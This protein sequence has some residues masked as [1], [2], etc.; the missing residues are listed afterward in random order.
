MVDRHFSQPDMAELYDYFNFWRCTPQDDFYLDLVMDAR[1]VLDAGCGTG[2]LQ[3]VARERGHTGRLV[4]LDPADAMLEVGRRD[5]DDIEWTLGDLAHGPY[6]GEAG[7]PYEDE[8]DLIVMTGHAFQELTTDDELRKALASVRRA[9]TG[10]GRFVFETRNP[11]ARGWEAWNPERARTVNGPGGRRATCVHRLESV[12]GDLV[13]FTSSYT[14][15]GWAEPGHSRSTLR[16]LDADTLNG[17][18]AEAGLAV[19][20]QYGYWDR[21]PLTEASQEIITFA[22]SR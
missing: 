20:A 19:S 11:A 17:F 15:E 2:K 4:G 14:V 16:F 9:L 8:F 18:L 13:T 5:R 3:R 7:G 21:G 10:D 6:D 22:R 1:S 12:E